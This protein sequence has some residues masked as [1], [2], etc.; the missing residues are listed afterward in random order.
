MPK[1]K[2]KTIIYFFQ[3]YWKYGPL[4]FTEFYET[5][6][7]MKWNKNIYLQ[8]Y[9]YYKLLKLIKEN[10]LVHILPLYGMQMCINTYPNSNFGSVSLVT[11]QLRLI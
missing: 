5:L 10:M 6:F 11:K 8:E 1:K 4:F 9:W 3:C 2:I 7:K